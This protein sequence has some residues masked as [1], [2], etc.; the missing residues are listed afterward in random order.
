MSTQAVTWLLPK[1]YLNNIVVM[2]LIAAL[3]DQ[4]YCSALFQQYCSAM[5]RRLPC[6]LLLTCLF[7]R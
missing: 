4:Q 3:L 6:L 1:Q 2:P 5:I 7:Q